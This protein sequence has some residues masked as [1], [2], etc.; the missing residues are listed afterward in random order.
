[1]GQ[2]G[3]S[4]GHGEA[5]LDLLGAKLNQAGAKQGQ[6]EVKLDQVSTKMGHVGAKLWQVEAVLDLI[7]KRC[8]KST[9]GVTQ[10]SGAGPGASH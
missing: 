9:V 4:W 6:V 3:P 2:V 1:M 5:R 10:T 7:G 8:H